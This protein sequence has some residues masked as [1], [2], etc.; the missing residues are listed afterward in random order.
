MV[1]IVTSTRSSAREPDDPR[2]PLRTV[3]ASLPLLLLVVGAD[4]RIQLAVGGVLDRPM[5]RD[6]VRVGRSLFDLRLEDPAFANDARRALAGEDVTVVHCLRNDGTLE[7]RWRPLRDSTGQVDG[8]VA[9]AVEL[10]STRAQEVAAL[11]AAEQ[12]PAALWLTDPELQVTMLSGSVSNLLAGL[13]GR[14]IDELAPELGAAAVEAHRAALQGRAGRFRVALH[15]HQLE[16][17]VAPLLEDEGRR[18]GCVGLAV[19]V[20]ESEALLSLLRATLES[21][22]DGLLVVDRAGRIVT[23]NQRFC[24]IWRLPEQLLC[25]RDDEAVLS[26][27]LATLKDPDVFMRRVKDL[28]ERPDEEAFDAIELKDGRVLERY[29]RPQRLDGEVVG[30]VWSF[31]DVTRRYRAEQERDHLLEAERRA[32]AHAEEEERR[33]KAL[34]D[35]VDAILWERLVD[36]DDFIYVS[37][38]GPVILGYP[39]ERWLRPGFWHEVVVAADHEVAFSVCHLPWSDARPRR[40]EYRVRTADGRERWVQDHV[41]LV[42]DEAGQVVQLRGIILDIT[43]RKLVQEGLAASE[44]RLRALVENT[45]HV[46]IQG[47]DEQGRVLSWN[48]AS[49]H[50]YGYGREEALGRTLD[51]LGFFDARQSAAFAGH[52]REVARSGVAVGPIELLGRHR[53]GR[54]LVIQ[55]T[56]FATPGPTEPRL[57]CMDVDL[58]EQRRAEAALAAHASRLEVVARVSREL[59]GARLHIGALARTLVEALAGNVG[60]TCVVVVQGEVDQEID[61]IEAH[62]DDAGGWALAARARARDGP[63]ADVLA[64]G[65]ACLFD[66]LHAPP[67]FLCMVVA[68]IVA[69]GQVFGTLTVARPLGGRPCDDD[70]R[71]LVEDLAER[72][73]LAVEAARL[74][75][76]AESAIRH[77]DEFLS[78]ASHELRTPLQSLGLI[79][80]GLQVQARR[81]G[82]VAALDPRAVGRLLD[83][84]SRQQRRLSRLVDALLDVTRLEAGRLHMDLDDVDLGQVVQEV[85]DLFRGELTQA[86]CELALRVAPQVVG[87]WDR[88]RLEQVVA[89]LLS[90][91]I[92]YGA[93][94]PIEV[95]VERRGALARAAVRDH[96]IGMEASTA[97]QIFQRF[98]RGVSARHYGGLGL[99]LFIAR[100]IVEA[101]G[102]SIHVDSVPGRGS[103]FTFELPLAGPGPARAGDRGGAP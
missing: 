2:D 27:A 71:R 40:L 59:D 10:T 74:L 24:E 17:Y 43:E 36:C 11:R 34:V 62:P 88:G 57:F 92:K 32:R 94:R 26:T 44:A 4:G 6:Q 28:Y 55:S 38:G 9:L 5:F 80:Q 70:D 99:G 98:K 93:G 13:L 29:S 35:G 25:S 103:T 20:T 54:E 77:R 97:R 63:W 96:G 23:Y 73:G 37:D 8:A 56:I 48:Q 82:G 101:L 90:N 15:G 91:A 16:A 7:V 66:G 64:R 86:R 12:A 79:V 33:R 52:L 69:R 81:P 47:Y 84:L 42:L 1:R 30:R 61:A 89:N 102:G 75:R 87:R 76:A 51:E 85:V 19:D 3:V 41:S 60:A 18:A 46:G 67:G 100:Q 31:R 72:A 50:L 83:S 68:P 39:I 65:R 21:T 78:V 14:R 22:E 58:T 53:D 45:P 95:M 49:T